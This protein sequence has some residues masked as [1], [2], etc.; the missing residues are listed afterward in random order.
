M[1]DAIQAHIYLIIF[2]HSL[3][4]IVRI[5]LQYY[6]KEKKVRYNTSFRIRCLLFVAIELEI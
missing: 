5:K 1:I 3:H 6:K 2:F 4:V